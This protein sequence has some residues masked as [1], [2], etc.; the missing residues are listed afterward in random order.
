MFIKEINKKNKGSKKSYTYYRLV[1]SYRN[2]NGDPRHRTLLN[3][4]KLDIA[5]EDWQLL[6]KRI[7]AKI[8][9][10]NNTIFDKMPKYI[11]DLASHYSELLINKQFQKKT[12]QLTELESDI[13][14]SETEIETEKIIEPDY[15]VIDL[16]SLK[17]ENNRTIAIEYICLKTWNELG[18]DK[19]LTDCGFNEN[20]INMAKI[21]IIG[22]ASNPGSENSLRFWAQNISALDEL[23]NTNFNSLSNNGLYRISDK[24][25]ENKE[26]IEK[27]LREKER[28]L[29]SLK[30]KILLYDLTNTYFEGRSLK[31]KKTKRS[32]KS[33]EK[34]TDCPLITL[35]LL[36]DTE[37]FLQHTEIFEG[38]VS[39]PGT[40]EIIINEFEKYQKNSLFEIKPTIVMDAGISTEENIKLL[41]KKGYSYLVVS[42]KKYDIENPESTELIKDDIEIKK[43][44][45]AKIIKQDDE[46]TILYCNSEQKKAKEKSI[47][48]YFN[49]RF[50]EEI[51][52]ISSGLQKKYCTKNYEKILMRIG[53]LKEKYSKVA[54]YYD[55]TVNN[56]DDIATSID[57]K[58]KDKV[59]IKDKFNGSYFLRTNLKDFSEK[60]L[61][62]IYIQL[63]RIEDVFRT[64]KQYLGFRP[65]FHQID[66][67]IS[68]HINICTL[69][70]HLINIVQTKLQKENINHSWK[71]IRECMETQ[72]RVTTTLI[73]DK[74][75]KIYM[76]NCV[77]PTKFQQKIYKTLKIRSIPMEQV[78]IKI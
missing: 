57:Y 48:N 76:R 55:I 13:D 66:K 41:K 53:R 74:K 69:S 2:L 38:N 54:Q 21:Q 31:S 3:L 16:N 50:I 75:E 46:E 52:K 61:W 35:G 8:S 24:L 7:E 5:K 78:K 33:K 20:Q 47:Q 18:F 42:R 15:E 64:L 72:T 10:S 29:Y 40:L 32:R 49:T 45:K 27:K 59:E 28:S 17:N 65:V 11:D 4:E 68:G 36:T 23:L 73:N 56:K 30:S 43:G 6:A 71:F 77:H 1:E 25:Y 19:I 58:I 14:D 44:I 34:R 22:M 12:S 26:E 51:K 62:Y 67:R 70:F 9:G 60:E 37:G 63:N 39:E